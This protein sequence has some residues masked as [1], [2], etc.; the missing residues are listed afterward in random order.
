MTTK[1]KSKKT[2]TKI[3]PGL[4]VKHDLYGTGTVLTSPVTVDGHDGGMDTHVDVLWDEPE[5]IG[6]VIGW[7]MTRALVATG[8]PDRTMVRLRRDRP[9]ALEPKPKPEADS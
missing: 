5:Y 8:E 6:G 2:V 9:V 1:T 4:R 7:P 3:V